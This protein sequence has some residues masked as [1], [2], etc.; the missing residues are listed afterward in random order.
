MAGNSS[1]PF[2]K[3]WHIEQVVKQPVTDLG[4]LAP[5]IIMSCDPGGGQTGPSDTAI[6]SLAPSRYAAPR[7]PVGLDIP[8]SRATHADRHWVVRCHRSQSSRRQS[9]TAWSCA[10]TTASGAS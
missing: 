9:I 5:V 10:L 3:P 4:E 6:V 7:A 1:E 2:F 8:W